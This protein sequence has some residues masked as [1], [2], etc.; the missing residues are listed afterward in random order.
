MNQIEVHIDD[1]STPFFETAFLETPEELAEALSNAALQTLRAHDAIDFTLSLAVVDD[2]K[3]H[4]VN[5]QFLAHDYPTDVITFEL[6][7][8]PETG[9]RS[10]EIVVSAETA[11]R[12]AGES[13]TDF[14]S[15]LILYV[16]HGCLHLVGFDDHSPDDRD[17]MRS[18]EQAMM[19]KLGLEYAFDSE[20]AAE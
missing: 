19:N 18:A 5:R 11:K 8:D 20:D 3:I 15:E 14:A 1:N 10:A 17:A 6:G 13:G 4:E 9:G 2:A 16:V 7:E 12:I